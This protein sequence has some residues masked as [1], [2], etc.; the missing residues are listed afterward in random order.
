M[1]LKKYMKKK[2]EKSKGKNKKKKITALKKGK[3]MNKKQIQ[4]DKHKWKRKK[5]EKER[6]QR[7]NERNITKDGR[8]KK[9]Q[10]W[11]WNKILKNMKLIKHEINE[12]K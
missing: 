5:K 6:K 1:K 2:V 11:T 3:L 7:G 8:L 4:K 12:K 9:E 10:K